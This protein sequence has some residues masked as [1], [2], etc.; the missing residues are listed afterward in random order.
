MNADPFPPPP[1]TLLSKKGPF[2]SK[3]TIFPRESRKGTRSGKSASDPASRPCITPFFQF[4][5]DVGSLGE[6][7]PAEMA[8]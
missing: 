4:P 1:F 8:S 5:S 6:H 3:R 7:C 2:P